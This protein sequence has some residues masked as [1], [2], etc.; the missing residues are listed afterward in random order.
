MTNSRKGFTL[1]EILVAL[2]ILAIGMAM[3]AAIFPAAMEF[4]RVSHNSTLGTIMCENAL[5]VSELMLTQE[6][7]TSDKL[8]IFVDD[9]DDTHIY[10]E[11]KPYYL[12]KDQQRYPTGKADARTGFAMLARKMSPGVF[13]IVTVAYRKTDKNNTVELVPITCNFAEH[14]ITLTGTNKNSLRIGT[15]VI[16]ERTGAIAFV[17]SVNLQGT[18]GTVKIVPG[19]TV[20]GGSSY[21]LVE[22]DSGGSV[23][24]STKIRRSPAIGAMSK[25]NGLRSDPQPNS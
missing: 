4:N 11:A 2:G 6:I 25:M 15:P 24:D 13:Q 9:N 18:A 1:A 10:S 22:C 8:E 12:K 14:V 7:V 20:Q 19:Q 5:V 23:I 3:V 21:V 16:N 17:D